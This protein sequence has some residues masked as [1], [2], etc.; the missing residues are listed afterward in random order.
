M[1]QTQVTPLSMQN[2]KKDSNEFW[3]VNP[4]NSGFV[5]KVKQPN[6]KATT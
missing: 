1:L 2:H 6:G 4:N 3:K 5:K